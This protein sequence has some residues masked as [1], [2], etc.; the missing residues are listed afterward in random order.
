MSGRSSCRVGVCRDDKILKLAVNRINW[1]DFINLVVEEA[2]NKVRNEQ[3]P[4]CISSG[5]VE[6]TI[7]G[8]VSRSLIEWLKTKPN[9]VDDGKSYAGSLET[10][11]E[12][13]EEAAR[14]L[15]CSQLGFTKEEALS[16]TFDN[17]SLLSRVCAGAQPGQP[18]HIDV[19]FGAAQ[20]LAALTPNCRPTLVRIYQCD[21]I[22]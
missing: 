6:V 21:E 13:Y 5:V 17:H 11:R 16:V 18:P 3:N 20:F 9:E 19:E 14:N 15:L 1:V 4:R 8:P 7:S 12:A 10:V 22:I 2:P